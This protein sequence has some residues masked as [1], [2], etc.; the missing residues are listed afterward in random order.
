MKAGEENDQINFMNWLKR[1]HYEVWLKTHHSPN[2]GHRH[3]VTA[4]RMKLMGVKPGFPDL[5]FFQPVDGFC[6]LV[7]EL[8]FGKN[9]TTPAQIFWLDILLESGFKTKVC[10]GIEEAKKTFLDYM[11]L[12]S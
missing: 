7:V 8:K 6:G 11:E 10:Y 4:M 3:K 1:N 2:G 5:V 12:R 9:K